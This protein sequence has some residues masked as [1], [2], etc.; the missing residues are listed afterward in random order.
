MHQGSPHYPIPNHL[1][2]LRSSLFVNSLS[3]PALLRT[4]SFLTQSIRDTPTKLL[5]HFIS[6]SQEHSL[7]FFQHFSYP[8]HLLRTTPL[9]QLLLH[10]DRHFFAFIPYPLLLRT[11]FSSPDAL[12]PSFN[13][14]YI[15]HPFHIP[16]QLSLATPV[17]K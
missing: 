12:Y 17:L 15:P 13:F 3:I 5:K 9:V 11:L 16:H 7:S 14:V 8:M 6:S 4:S 2:T 1:N 10:I